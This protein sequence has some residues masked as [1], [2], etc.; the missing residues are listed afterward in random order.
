[1]FGVCSP[2]ACIASVYVSEGIKAE[3]S[4][5]SARLDMLRNPLRE[6]RSVSHRNNYPQCV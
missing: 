2:V 3:V 1:M 4:K 6:F 5:L